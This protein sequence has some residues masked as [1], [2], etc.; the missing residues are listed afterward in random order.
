MPGYRLIL[1]LGL[2]RLIVRRESIFGGFNRI[3]R[4]MVAWA[5][6][7]LLASFFQVWSPGSGPKY[8]AGN[9]MNAT[10]SYFLIRAWCHGLTETK[11]LLKAIAVLLAPVAVSMFLELLLHRNLFSVLGA[12]GAVFVRDGKIRALGPF[13]HPILAGTVGSVL[14]AYMFAIWKE[15]RTYAVIGIVATTSMVLSSNSSGPLMGLILT[16][17]ALVAWWCRK[18]MKVFLYAALGLYILLDLV[19]SR[20]AYFVISKINLTGS[21]TGWH[22]ARLIQASIEHFS[23]WF[24]FGTQN[25]LHWIGIPIAADPDSSDITNYYLKN[26]VDGGFLAM[27]LVILMIWCAFSWV[28]RLINSSLISP[29]HNKFSIWC[30]GAGLFNFAISSLSVSYNDQT[31]IFFWLCVSL[32]SALYACYHKARPRAFLITHKPP[33]PSDPFP[34]RGCSR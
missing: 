11:A 29:A 34:C 14:Y 12:S 5:G 16:S 32:I 15:H 23:D 17:V 8:A 18:W 20:P 26:G 30:L 31:I 1:A 24:L 4:L 2:L 21:S 27:L 7:I 13:A 19:M 9:I 10:F 33:R 6:W 22:R 25:T 28:G 3:D